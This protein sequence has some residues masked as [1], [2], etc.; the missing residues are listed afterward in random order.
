MMTFETA[1]IKVSRGQ[2]P[3]PIMFKADYLVLFFVDL[4]FL[5]PLFPKRIG[6][7]IL[8]QYRQINYSSDYYRKTNLILVMMG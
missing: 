3:C 5:V 7:L 6:L 8:R 4:F 1:F 2:K